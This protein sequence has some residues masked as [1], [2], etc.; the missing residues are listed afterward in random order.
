MSLKSIKENMHLID[1][2]D[3]LVD[4]LIPE[5]VRSV[6]YR[7]RPMQD[8]YLA[9]PEL[10]SKEFL[11]S[12][13][14]E[15]ITNDKDSSMYDLLRY[16]I[17]TKLTSMLNIYSRLGYLAVTVFTQKISGRSR[18]HSMPA[19]L[20]VINN[21]A[22]GDADHRGNTYR[23][24]GSIIFTDE[25]YT[26][27]DNTSPYAVSPNGYYVLDSRI[28]RVLLNMPIEDFLD[29]NQ[30]RKLLE[31]IEYALPSIIRIRTAKAA[32]MLY[33]EQLELLISKLKK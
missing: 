6:I 25:T 31:C 13:S 18:D 27:I 23:V 21:Y 4:S 32:P 12:V 7:Q 2:W 33:I 26:K 20:E 16:Q 9:F 29:A 3:S 1:V 28:L 22:S 17:S 10:W 14:L 24:D 15:F 30:K 19:I 5:E 11:S 8:S